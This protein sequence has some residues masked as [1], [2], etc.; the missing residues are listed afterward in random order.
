[1]AKYLLFL[2][3][4][5]ISL[6]SNDAL[7]Q[8]CYCTT[9]YY[10]NGTGAFQ[11]YCIANADCW[12][13]APGAYN[14][15]WQQAF[16]SGYTPPP[17]ACTPETQTQTLSCPSGYNGSITQTNTKTCPTGAWSGWVTSS[18]TCV[19]TC[20]PVT[21][22]RLVSCPVNYS[23]SI[24]ESRTKTCP[25]NQWQA[26]QTNQNTCVA[27]P[28]TCQA[29]SESQSS[30]CPVN[31][32]GT[33]VSTRTSSCPNP[34][35]SPVW[36]PW[37]EQRS[38]TQNPP[39][40]KTSTEV[41]SCP[42]NQSGTNSRTST[43]PDPYGQPVFADWVSTCTWNPAT[44]KTTTET[45]TLSCPTGFTGSIIQTR[46]STCQDPYGQPVMGAWTTT[47]DTCVK[48]IS[49]PTN[50]TSPV[51]QSIINPTVTAPTT[52]LLQTAPLPT[53]PQSASPMETPAEAPKQETSSTSSQPANQTTSSSTT[54]TSQPTSSQPPKPKL[55]IGG[56]NLAS[57][58]DLVSK[59][60]VQY[61]S[62]PVQT[63]SQEMP[64]EVRLY[65]NMMMDM[66]GIKPINQD[67]QFN[68]L[69]RDAME[70]EQ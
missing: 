53:T 62:L 70:F 45:Q 11:N 28:P 7:A 21:E 57:S 60:M 17:P 54:S 52:P 39:T 14:T 56:L 20:V 66:I 38:C 23:G 9:P 3:L 42:L 16:C 43:C 8:S 47:T 4:T 46:S 15:A 2:L 33:I 25:D 69:G 13:C 12:A 36:G 51:A 55:S 29:S 24:T 59:P 67:E 30:S 27:N 5:L 31:Q 65:N 64:L 61:N 22:T 68:L 48:S 58:L 49:N 32:S 26:W 19:S 1:M 34:Y 41:R 35:G 18:S 44:C 6:R 50:P 37:Q 40:C 63:M 10:N